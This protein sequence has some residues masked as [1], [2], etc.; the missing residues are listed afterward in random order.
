MKRNESRVRRMIGVTFEGG[1]LGL[2]GLLGRLGRLGLLVLGLKLL[3][4]DLKF[5]LKSLGSSESSMSSMEIVEK[6]SATSVDWVDVD[7]LVSWYPGGRRPTTSS[8]TIV[9]VGRFDD[10]GGV[11]DSGRAVVGGLTWKSGGKT[12]T[13]MLAKMSL[14]DG[15]SVVVV[16]VLEKNRAMSGLGEFSVVVSSSRELNLSRKLYRLVVVVGDDDDVLE[17]VDSVEVVVVEVEEE[18]SEDVSSK[19]SSYTIFCPARCLKRSASDLGLKVVVVVV[20]VG[21]GVLILNRLNRGAVVVVVDVVVVVVVVGSEVAS[22][23]CSSFRMCA[24]G[25]RPDCS[26]SSLSLMSAAVE[27]EELDTE[28]DVIVFVGPARGRGVS[29]SDVGM[30][31]G[32]AAVV[33]VVLFLCRVLVDGGRVGMNCTK[34]CL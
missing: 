8:C 13:G 20:V 11:A 27:E 9:V 12:S 4:V 21:G 1:P 3:P 32:G 17:D 29:G 26:R 31:A 24:H 6:M 19:S 28:T 5:S 22:V 33:V 15:F 7:V 16:V 18:A 30:K 10:D 2:L 34:S 23:R 14:T 25:S